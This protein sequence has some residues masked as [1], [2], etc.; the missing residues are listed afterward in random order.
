MASE[1]KFI[2]KA[3]SDFAIKEFLQREL[4][5]AGVS[6]IEIQKTPI[7]TR[8]AIAVRRP[9][10]VVGKKGQTIK[11]ISEA[12]QSK[13][14]IENPQ[15]EVIEVAQPSLD[16]KLMAEKIGKQLEIKGNTKTAMRFALREIMSAGAI[17]AEIRA[18]GKL[19]GKG[20]KAKS[21]TIRAGFLK[22]SGEESKK[23]REGHFTAYMK[24]GAIGITVK[25]APP[26]TKF[27]DKV[28]LSI[29]T[30][31]VETEKILDVASEKAT[32]KIDDK[33][34][35]VVKK[36]VAKPKSE[37]TATDASAKETVEAT[38]AETTPAVVQEK[39]EPT[40]STESTKPT[41]APQGA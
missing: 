30:I 25:I 10:L 13:Y 24:A 11:D 28:D 15:I 20:G 21:T 8:I 7:A 31:P 1:R 33:K 38:P 37:K 17:G 19:V 29:L 40:A 2:Q 41:P 16:A 36:R 4:T 6:T 32:E 12:L 27:S 14:G 35:R 39:T 22:K 5:N 23:M 3:I 9:G 18:A 26:G 34:K